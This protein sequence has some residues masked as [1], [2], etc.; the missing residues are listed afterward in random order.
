MTEKRT[1]EDIA[2]LKRAAAVRNRLEAARGYV[3]EA[4]KALDEAVKLAEQDRYASVKT[5][6]RNDIADMQSVLRVSV[7]RP[8][9]TLAARWSDI[10]HGRQTL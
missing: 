1:P 6:D 7:I 8:L 9:N 2:D 10:V 3:Q 5:Y 4:Q